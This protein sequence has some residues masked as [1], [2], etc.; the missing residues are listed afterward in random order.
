MTVA[1][2]PR[3]IEKAERS[4]RL[5]AIGQLAGVV[6]HDLNNILQVINGYATLVVADLPADHPGQA[7]LAQILRV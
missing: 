3:I 4:E 5:E 2:R 7:A 6:A 1:Q